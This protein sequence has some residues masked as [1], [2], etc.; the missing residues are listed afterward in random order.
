MYIFTNVR[1]AFY[2]CKV[3][4]M[5]GTK[6]KPWESI[7]KCIFGTELAARVQC[8]MHAIQPC[9]LVT[10]QLEVSGSCCTDYSSRGKRD[11]KQGAQAKL[12]L[13]WAR[14]HRTREMPLIIHENV[15]TFDQSVLEDLFL[16]DCKIFQIMTSPSEVGLPVLERKRVYHVMVHRRRA[17]VLD[18]I[19]ACYEARA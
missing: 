17:R 7:K 1:R 3:R 19:E 5:E 12:L 9:P 8:H 2:I 13:T 10:G 4:E 14:L 16:K 6:T 18:N 11:G 15:R